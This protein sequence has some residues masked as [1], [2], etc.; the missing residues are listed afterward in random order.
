MTFWEYFLFLFKPH[1][2]SDGWV[3]YESLSANL[4]DK[5]TPLE[6]VTFYVIDIESTGLDPETDRILSLCAIPVQ[7]FQIRIDNML[8][9]RVNQDYY[10]SES[11]SIHEIMPEIDLED[12]ISEKEALS[13]LLRMAGAGIWVAHFCDLDLK[14]IQKAAKR[15]G[16]MS[17]HNPVLDTSLLLSRAVDHYRNP[18]QMPQGSFQLSKVCNKLSIPIEGLHT[19]EGDAL[20]TAILF[21]KLVQILKKRGVKTLKELL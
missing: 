9:L 11:I 3:D 13:A 5:K 18:E 12:G 8:S 21:T 2:S 1:A 15:H 7:Q 20:A 4:P 6:D 14:L 16:L 19:A 17:I 10:K